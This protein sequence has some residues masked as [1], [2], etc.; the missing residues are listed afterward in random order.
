MTKT[1]AFQAGARPVFAQTK[2]KQESD[3]D[4][5]AYHISVD[6][7][8]A[9][10]SVYSHH[11]P[12]TDTV[13]PLRYRPRPIPQ[14]KE[15]ILEQYEEEDLAEKSIEPTLY[16]IDDR[17]IEDDLATANETYIERPPTPQFAEE[18][19]LLQLAC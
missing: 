9:R 17:P 11:K 3:N 7:R 13:Q 16:E 10:G 14:P 19:P 12:P 18:P 5:T 6:P 4:R 15:E 8:V 1:F 2:F